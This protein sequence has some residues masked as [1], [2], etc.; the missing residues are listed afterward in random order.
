MLTINPLIELNPNESLAGQADRIAILYRALPAGG[1]P[2]L[3]VDVSGIGESFAEA[4]IERGLTVIPVG[5]A[6]YWKTPVSPDDICRECGAIVRSP[7]ILE[8]PINCP[9]CGAPIN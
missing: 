3:A 2:A 5:R 1:R 8:T 7:G 6:A 9:Q 4:L